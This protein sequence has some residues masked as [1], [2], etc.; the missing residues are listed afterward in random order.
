MW[1]L[2]CRPNC[3][4]V[5]SSSRSSW[6]SCSNH[7]RSVMERSVAKTAEFPHFG[8]KVLRIMDMFNP[9]PIP[10]RCSCPFNQIEMR[11][12]SNN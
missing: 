12:E 11:R 6:I 8:P 3:L 10:R 2:C 9:E 5:R 7:K 4:R 1:L